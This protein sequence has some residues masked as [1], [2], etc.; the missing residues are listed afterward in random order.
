MLQYPFPGL[1]VGTFI[2]VPPLRRSNAPR[3]ANFPALGR[4]LSLRGAARR[5]ARSPTTG[6]P[7]LRAGT[8]IEGPRLHATLDRL[9]ISLPSGGD[10]H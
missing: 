7:R 1:R 5:R 3:L 9:R 4:G 2:E 6:F 8:F 10:F